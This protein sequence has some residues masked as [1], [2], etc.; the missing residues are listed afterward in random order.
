MLLDASIKAGAPINSAHI[1][2]KE[3]EKAGF[4]NIVQW[5]DVWPGGTWPKDTRLRELGNTTYNC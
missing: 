1:Y 3:M 4:V 5:K 2:K